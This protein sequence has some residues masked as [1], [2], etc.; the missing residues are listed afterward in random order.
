MQALSGKDQRIIVQGGRL[1]LCPLALSVFRR[2]PAFQIQP[3]KPLCPEDFAT[4][5]ISLEYAPV[6][7]LGSCPRYAIPI[8]SR[9]ASGL[10]PATACTTSS[11][12]HACEIAAIS[13]SN[14]N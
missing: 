14:Y 3:L 6:R 10:G 13:K 9:R 11:A 2:S 1:R 7:L 5:L 4:D 8:N 12:P